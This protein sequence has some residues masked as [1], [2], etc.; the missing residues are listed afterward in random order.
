MISFRDR[1]ELVE[2]VEQ[3]ADSE[4]PAE[5]VVDGLIE[6]MKEAGEITNFTLQSMQRLKQ[7]GFA[8]SAMGETAEAGIIDGLAGIGYA[9]LASNENS[10]AFYALMGERG[11]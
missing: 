7:A 10:E 4:K 6:D 8:A 9:I 1:K 2:F 3:C 5:D 11:R